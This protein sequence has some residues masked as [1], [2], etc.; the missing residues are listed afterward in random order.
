[1]RYARGDRPAYDAGMVSRG[2][3]FRI[4]ELCAAILPD[5]HR[6]GQEWVGGPK[7]GRIRVRL[8]GHKQG[9]WGQF[10]AGLDVAGDALDLV[11]HV[12]FGGDKKQAYR[13][14]LVWLGLD[15]GQAPE[16]AA[17][18][19]PTMPAEAT[20]EAERLQARARALWLSG[21]PLQGTPAAEY[22]AGRGVGPERLG[23][24]PGALRFHAEV[25]E[26]ETGAKLPAML[27]MIQA[28]TEQV[29]VHR[30]YLAP[31]PGGGWGKAPIAS[32][33]KVL[34]RYRGGFIPLWRGVS[35]VPIAR[36]PEDQV[37]AIAEG[38]EDGL[39]VALHQPEWRVVAAISVGNMAA[40]VLPPTALDVVLVLDRD[41]ENPA[42]R[43]ARAAAQRALLAQGRSVRVIMPEDGYKDFNDWH[44]ATLGAT[45]V[46]A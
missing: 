44:R 32:A 34:G 36:H 45:Q 43:R 24:Y 2:L 5:G 22:L 18:I 8:S 17:Q 37:L 3:A 27:A 12:Q 20:E 38:I 26:A 41:G 9:V 1:M 13:W 15:S 10:A 23:K 25:W 21:A 11:A 46:A 6:E 40:V 39:T 31:R 29:A 16:V 35:G 14:S 33:K 30:T 7:G 42:V 19:P 4:S 28:G